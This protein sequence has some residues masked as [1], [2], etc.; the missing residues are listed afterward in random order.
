AGAARMGI[1]I[2][3]V[4]NLQSLTPHGSYLDR[5]GALSGSLDVQAGG[6]ILGVVH[7]HETSGVAWTSL[8]ENFDFVINDNNDGNMSGASRT[9][10]TATTGHSFSVTASHSNKVL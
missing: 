10:A 6:A 2:W 4:Q 7:S 1:G 9:F 8:T 3:A 5:S